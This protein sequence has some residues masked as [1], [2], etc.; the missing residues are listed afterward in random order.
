MDQRGKKKCL[1]A[2]TS[3]TPNGLTQL[4]TLNSVMTSALEKLRKAAD[5]STK[6][7]NAGN[8]KLPL[9]TLRLRT[10]LTKPSPYSS[11]YTIR[12]QVLGHY[13]RLHDLKAQAHHPSY[14]IIPK[15]HQNKRDNP[16]SSSSQVGRYMQMKCSGP[17][18]NNELHDLTVNKW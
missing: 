5:G 15:F 16:S 18:T 12:E 1:V 3:I 8:G 4:Y 11:E 2:S 9:R 6:A 17:L 7:V 13:K 10:T 14:S